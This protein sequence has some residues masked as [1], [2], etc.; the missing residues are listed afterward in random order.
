[1]YV[2]NF[3]A[4]QCGLYL[5][6]LHDNKARDYALN[7]LE[8]LIL[9]WS[10]KSEKVVSKVPLTALRDGYKPLVKNSQRFMN[11]VFCYT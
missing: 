5:T 1:M 6:S 11:L 10:K 8:N 7:K 9:S 2:F 4:Q 3:I